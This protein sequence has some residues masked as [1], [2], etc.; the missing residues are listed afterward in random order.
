MI[1]L[2]KIGKVA[3]SLDALVCRNL[4]AEFQRRVLKYCEHEMAKQE[5]M[6]ELEMRECLPTK[7]YT[8]INKYMQWSA[9]A[10]SQLFEGCELAFLK[11]LV[12]R[13]EP[14]DYGPGD[15]IS[16][17]GELNKVATDLSVTSSSKTLA[18]NRKMN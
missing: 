7:L 8:R 14:M 3:F 12:A 2:E 5:K 4:H 11:D 1:I 16:A 6:T 9:L 17:R 13:L 18:S 10:H 15:V